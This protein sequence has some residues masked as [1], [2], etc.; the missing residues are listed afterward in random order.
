MKIQCLIHEIQEQILC[1]LFIL[2]S[3]FFKYSILIIYLIKYIYPMTNI[4]LQ[5]MEL[6]NQKLWI[7]L[8]LFIKSAR[9]F[10]LE[11]DKQKVSAF[12]E[13]KNI[14]L[15]ILLFSILKCYSSLFNSK[16]C[17]K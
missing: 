13:N 6:L 1:G 4:I 14:S 16:F 11:E 12:S 2:S 3:W 8:N 15:N 5:K 17:V 7:V 10:V 9:S